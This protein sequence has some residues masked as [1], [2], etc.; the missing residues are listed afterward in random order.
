MKKALV[1]LVF[2]AGTLLSTSS[3]FAQSAADMWRSA[4][5]SAYQVK[6]ASDQGNGRTES[7]ACFDPGAQ[8][9]WERCQLTAVAGRDEPTGGYYYTPRTSRLNAYG[10]NSYLRSEIA[11]FDCQTPRYVLRPYLVSKQGRFSLQA[12][13]V[14]LDGAAALQAPVKPQ[15][16]LQTSENYGYEEKA[17]L[18]ADAKQIIALRKI[19]EGGKVAIRFTGVAGAMSVK[20]QDAAKFSRDVADALAIYDALSAA[21][22]PELQQACLAANQ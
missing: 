2:V 5:T 15:S 11:I 20:P 22:T 3:A 13:T 12:V 4:L 9:D 17:Y 19:A 7:Y 16:V 6:A 21:I 10:T 14:M 1:P 8:P 18:I